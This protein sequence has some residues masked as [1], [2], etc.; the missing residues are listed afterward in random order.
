MSLVHSPQEAAHT[1]PGS[2]ESAAYHVVT[3]GSGSEGAVAR[4][5]MPMPTAKGKMKID[6]LPVVIH[7]E[8]EMLA[9]VKAHAFFAAEQERLA[10]RDAGMARRLEAARTARAAKRGGDAEGV[11]P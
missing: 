2:A 4:I 3:W 11:N 7:A 9:T 1:Q 8:T 6:W 5:R 10:K